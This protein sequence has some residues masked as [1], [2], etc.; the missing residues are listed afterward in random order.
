MKAV[1][2]QEKG[3][4]Q[5]ERAGWMVQKGQD[6]MEQWKAAKRDGMDKFPHHSSL[7]AAT[8][9]CSGTPRPDRRERAHEHD[10][11]H[12]RAQSVARKT[13]P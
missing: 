3:G 2:E 1:A 8:L 7:L 10:R 6:F 5:G 4:V 12:T 11:A 9:G 13:H